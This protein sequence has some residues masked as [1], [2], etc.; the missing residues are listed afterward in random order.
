MKRL[1]KSEWEKYI[2]QSYQLIKSKLSKKK[3][4]ELGIVY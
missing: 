4:K 1:S 3:L 2:N